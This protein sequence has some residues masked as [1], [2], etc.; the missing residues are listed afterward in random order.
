MTNWYHEMK[1][2][3]KLNGT[4]ADFVSQLTHLLFPPK[5]EALPHG[6]CHLLVK[7]KPFLLGSQHDGI[8]SPSI[9]DEGL[10]RTWETL[11]V[12]AN[13]SA[14]PKMA[15]V[16]C[17]MAPC[18]RNRRRRRQSR[19]WYPLPSTNSDL[20]L[21]DKFISAGAEVVENDPEEA[22]D[23]GKTVEGRG[24]RGEAAI[25]RQRKGRAGRKT[26]EEEC[27]RNRCVEM[28]LAQ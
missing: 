2:E 18:Q 16:P 9:L 21:E 7:P 15:M 23:P 12:Q 20:Y 1:V 4:G 17:R 27:G 5:S 11:T 13:V 19:K 8:P 26:S 22:P 6:S 25:R 3:I 10:V 24:A 14:Q 28:G